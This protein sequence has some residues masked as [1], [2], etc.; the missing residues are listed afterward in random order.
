MPQVND[1]DQIDN[2]NVENVKALL[3]GTPDEP[4]LDALTVLLIAKKTKQIEDDS[5]SKLQKISEKQKIVAE[6]HKHLRAINAAT[7]EKG[8]LDLKNE[9]DLKDLLKR[10]NE[11][12]ADIDPTK[13]KYTPTE[14][15]RLVENIRSVVEDH[16]VE[17]NTGMQE[18]SR[19]HDERNQVFQLANMIKKSLQDPKLASIKKISP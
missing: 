1:V 14:R 2:L 3:A 8:D 10:A 13:E 15:E 11:L 18:V 16:N 7:G 19:L 4:S 6:F 9:P 12:G 17:I 5:S